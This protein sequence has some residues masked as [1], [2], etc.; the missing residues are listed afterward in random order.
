MQTENKRLKLELSYKPD[1]VIDTLV[2][3]DGP[4]LKTYLKVPIKAGFKDQWLQL[5]G[6]VKTTGFTMDSIIVY[7]EPQIV[8]GWSKKFL[9]KSKPIIDFSDKNPYTKVISMENK[10]IVKPVPFYRNPWFYRAEG[11]VVLF[12]VLE[13]VKAIK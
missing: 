2:I 12:G 11:V 7:S 13:G 1:S 6:T 3:H 8:I 4:N 5:D 10:I 9:K